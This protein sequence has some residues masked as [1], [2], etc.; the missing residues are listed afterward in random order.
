MFCAKRPEEKSFGDY[1][2]FPGGKIE[3]NEIPKEALVREIKEEFVSEIEILSFLNEASYK[4][5]F[6]MVKMKTYH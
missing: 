5:D 1:W 3:A 6:G 2:E 4:Y